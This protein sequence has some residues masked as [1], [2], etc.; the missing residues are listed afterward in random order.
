MQY[1]PGLSSDELIE[2]A[3][4]TYFGNVDAK[5]MDA[6]L[7]CFHDEALFC[8][9]TDFT[10]HSGKAEIQR[11]FEDFFGAYEVIIHRDFVCTVDEA[12]GRIAANFIA[13]LKDSDGNVT[14]LNNTNFWRLRDGKFQ[15]V[16]VYMSGA[17]VLV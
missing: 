1:E 9:Q 16:Y 6:T 2:F 14:L 4:K 12:N 5:N 15:E 17:N 13:E 7:D 11:M 8:V 3:T 10:R